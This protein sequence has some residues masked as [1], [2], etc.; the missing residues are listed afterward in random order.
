MPHMMRLSAIA[1]CP[2]QNTRADSVTFPVALAF[3]FCLLSQPSAA[4]SF[5]DDLKTIV[6]ASPQFASLRGEAEGMQFH[7]TLRLEGTTQCE[8]R[9][10][11]D[12]DNNWQPINEKWSY[13]CLWENR[14]AQA[15]PALT[16][17]VGQCLPEAQYSEGSPLGA[18][19]AN[20]AGGVYRLD[21]TSIVT[22]YNKDTSQLWL[23]VLPPGVEQ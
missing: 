3:A 22:D 20:F 10:K 4:Q 17:L 6:A 23:T 7:G 18:K 8:I 9:N 14:T 13:E 19:F 1:L 12:L 21:D 5:C 11:S 15:L 16:A 2:L